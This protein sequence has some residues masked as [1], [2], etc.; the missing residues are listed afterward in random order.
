[1]RVEIMGKRGVKLTK[2]QQ[3]RNDAILSRLEEERSRLAEE[4]RAMQEQTKRK[5]NRKR[6][7]PTATAVEEQSE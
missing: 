1:V 5:P 4:T 2:D 7:K 3:Q 6:K